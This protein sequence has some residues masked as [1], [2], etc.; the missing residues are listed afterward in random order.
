MSIKWFFFIVRITHPC[1]GVHLDANVHLCDN[2]NAFS[3]LDG[4]LPHTTFCN[5]FSNR[6]HSCQY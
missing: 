2:R 4:S 3:K 1:C 6:V 5:S